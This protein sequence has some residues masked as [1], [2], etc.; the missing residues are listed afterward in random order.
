MQE[1]PHSY[2]VN[3]TG[4][5]DTN[6]TTSADGLPNIYVAP[7][8]QFGGPGDQW[9]P[10]ELLMAAVANCFVLSF[11]AI[12]RASKVE[13]LSIDCE[14]EGILEKSGRKMLFTK[15]ITKAKL[16]ISSG[17]N[18]EAAEKA[19]KRAEETCLITNSMS[20]EASLKY[21]VIE[22]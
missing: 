18:S 1:L 13:W 6:L 10:E 12:A 21:E 4:Q 17:Q 5:V 8:L 7:P 22:H 16:A 2:S 15:V 19:L 14:S 3:V 20:A 9:S 11:K